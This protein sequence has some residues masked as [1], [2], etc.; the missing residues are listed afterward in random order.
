[1]YSIFNTFKSFR[2]FCNGGICR[3]SCKFYF[4]VARLLVMMV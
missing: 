3:V 4:M 1:M 2:M